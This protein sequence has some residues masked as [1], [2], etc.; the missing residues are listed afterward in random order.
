MAE[1]EV[2]PKPDGNTE[3]NGAEVGNIVPPPNIKVQ[4][5]SASKIVPSI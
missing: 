4:F 1:A 5:P 2:A 3:A